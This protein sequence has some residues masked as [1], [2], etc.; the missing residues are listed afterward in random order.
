VT[1]VRR[2]VNGVVDEVGDYFAKEQWVS[3]DLD[4]FSSFV[5]G[6]LDVIGAHLRPGHSHGPTDELVEIDGLGRV[7]DAR[8]GS[9]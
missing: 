5:K 7:G 1:I 6:Q 3:F 8:G 9:A 4:L 2:G